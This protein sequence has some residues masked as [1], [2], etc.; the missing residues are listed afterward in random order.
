MR[1]V[2]Q[3]RVFHSALEENIAR[4]ADAGPVLVD[5]SADAF[6][7]GVERVA[8][9]ARE[10]GASG[11]FV[12]SADG[13]LSVRAILPDIDILVGRAA[14]DRRAELDSARIRSVSDDDVVIR[15]SA[16]GFDG[17]SRATVSFHSE[18]LS[19]KSIRAGDGVSYGYTYR[20]ERDGGTALVALGYGDG[21]HRH[22][23]NRCSVLVDGVTSPIIGRVAMNVFVVSLGD[24]SVELGAPVT[25]FGDPEA[26]EPPIAGWSEA[27][28]VPCS[29]VTAGIGGRVERHAS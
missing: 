14:P 12:A 18:V 13:A 3:L 11:V 7:L 5:V 1:P 20:A 19:T 10:A 27:L 22:A 21:I 9:S 6:G 29:V 15:D 17:R 8:A 26:G 2:R 25:I 23:G 28:G 16:Y 4:E 24:R